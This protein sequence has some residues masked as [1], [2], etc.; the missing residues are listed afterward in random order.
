MPLEATISSAPIS[1]CQPSP[2]LTR[3]PATS[4][5]TE[6]GSSTSVRISQLLAPSVCAAS[7]SRRSTYRA[8]R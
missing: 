2:A 5:G 3:T 4:D 1:D 8:P 6:A 7:T